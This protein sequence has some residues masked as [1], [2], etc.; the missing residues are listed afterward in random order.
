[1]TSSFGSLR[2]SRWTEGP[3]WNPERLRSWISGPASRAGK[4]IAR[5][6]SIA[7]FTIFAATGALALDFKPYG[8]GAFAQIVKTHAGKP[9]IIHFWSVT[10]PPCIAELPQWTK[11]ISDHA[12]IDVV[13]VNADDAEDRAR[14]EARV[15][16]AG[17]SKAN[18]YGFEDDFVDKLYFEADA[19]WRGELPF[20]ALVAPDGGVTAVTGAIDDPLVTR[21]LEKR[22]SK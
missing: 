20:T 17:L 19:S 1:M 22:G 21:W 12:E 15:E 14:A 18:H 13:F 8:R 9:L 3:I 2:H 10:C 16:K 5:A 6:A 11:L 4:N 7:A